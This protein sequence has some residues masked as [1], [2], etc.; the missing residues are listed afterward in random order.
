MSK[1]YMA[2]ILDWSQSTCPKLGAALE[3]LRQ[4]L[5]ELNEPPLSAVNACV[6][7]LVTQHL[8][9]IAFGATAWTFCLYHRCFELVKLRRWDITVFDQAAVDRVL[10]KYLADDELLLSDQQVPF[11]IYLTNCK[12][13][14][15]K[16]DK[17]LMEQDLRCNHYRIYSQ[18]DLPAS[19]TFAWLLVWLKWLEVAHYGRTLAPD[20][21]I[22]PMIG[23]N[24]VV[25]PREPLSHDTVQK[26][27]NEAVEGA[28]IPGSFSTH[29]FCHGDAQYRFM[30][31]PVGQHWMLAKVRWWGGWAEQEHHD[32][33]I[34]YLLNELHAYEVDYSDALAPVQ[35][36]I[37]QSLAGEAALIQ[38][39]STE[40]LRM[41]HSSVVGDIQEL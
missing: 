23:A 30:F 16:V 28:G 25:H 21:C 12:G 39:M 40:E 2:Q 26:W 7:Q 22:F 13:W 11:E 10:M 4:V 15:R 3:W 1:D 41:V 32:T 20:D 17:G 24:G 18:P 14:Q 35:Q 8:A 36:E 5:S 37:D 29:C 27:I 33:L 34:R 6:K 31:A 19:D 9:Q 38:P